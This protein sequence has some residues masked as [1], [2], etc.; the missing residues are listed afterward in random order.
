MRKSV[1][2]I[3]EKIEKDYNLSKNISLLIKGKCKFFISV[4]TF[5][6]LIDALNWAKNNSLGVS[7]L[8]NGT[9][10]T[11]PDY[12]DALVIKIDIKD[13]TVDQNNITA[14]AGVEFDKLI[15][16]S[17]KN[18]LYGL[19]NLSLIPG[20]VGASVIQNIGAYGVEVS[21]YIHEVE[22]LDLSTF[23]IKKATNKECEFVYRGSRFSKEK[24]IVLKVI[25]SLKNNFQPVTKYKDIKNMV[26]DSGKELREKIIDIRKE[27]FGE[28]HSAGSFFKNIELD[29]ESVNKFKIKYE[30][31][32]IYEVESG[33]KIPTAWVMDKVCNLNGYSKNGLKLKESN[34]VVIV[35][36]KCVSAIEL[37][38][39]VDDICVK[40]KDVSGIELENEVYELPIIKL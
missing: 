40:V 23:E 28:F 22:Y 30:N 14:T 13:V 6:D 35:T 39:F 38:S 7:V 34:P 31:A 1:N 18:D 11:I 37:W 27:K 29:N 15:D 24:V 17:L 16:F 5:E 12:L 2:N 8:G 36:E 20:T 19:E 10:V 26:F 9:N 3:E 33:Y 4:K 21:E 25:F 32:P